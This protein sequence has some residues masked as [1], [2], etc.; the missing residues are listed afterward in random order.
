M[1]SDRAEFVLRLIDGFDGAAGLKFRFS[2][3]ITETS[4]PFARTR[5]REHVTASAVVLSSAGVLLHLHKRLAIWVGPG[6]HVDNGESAPDAAAREAFEETGLYAWH[7]ASGPKLIDIDIHP[8]GD[9][10]HYDLRFLLGANPD[11]PSPPAGESQDV[12]WLEPVEAQA[13]TDGSYARAISRAGR[14]GDLLVG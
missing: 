9:D 11:D 4:D 2:R 3:F 14:F 5:Q 13:L 1:I 12:R 10:L 6:G 8:S 7:P